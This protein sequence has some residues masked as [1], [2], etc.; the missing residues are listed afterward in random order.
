MALEASLGPSTA[1]LVAV[2]QVPSRFIKN[3]A[4]GKD[5]FLHVKSVELWFFASPRGA[6]Q[7]IRSTSTA[8]LLPLPLDS[9]S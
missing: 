1:R 5:D 6:P 7:S 3:D 4:G 9:I 2:F 8:M